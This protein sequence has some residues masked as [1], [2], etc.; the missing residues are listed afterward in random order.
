MAQ[1]NITALMDLW[2]A[3]VLR[4][5][6]TPPF[7]DHVDLHRTIDATDLGAVSWTVLRISYVGPRPSHDV[8]P[9][10]NETF[11]LWYRDPRKVALKMLADPSFNGHFD[12]AA[13]RDFTKKGERRYSNL[14][15]GNWAWKISV[16]T[17]VY[18]LQPIMLTTHVCNLGR[19]ID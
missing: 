6:G 11:E 19:H 13:H 14:M 16:S 15:S 12:Y 2:A 17:L 9:W 18:L 3:D 5:G 1:S 7:S 8:P 4:Y 10:M